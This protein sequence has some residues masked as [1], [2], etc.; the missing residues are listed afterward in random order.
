VGLRQVLIRAYDSA[1]GPE[2]ALN[3]L[4]VLKIGTEMRFGTGPNIAELSI[5]WE[6]KKLGAIFRIKA[7][8]GNLSAKFPPELGMR[9]QAVSKEFHHL[10]L[11]V[12][13]YT[14]ALV[15]RG[16][17]DPMIWIP[18]SGRIVRKEADR[19]LSV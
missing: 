3:S 12:D 7:Q 10:I 16:Q 9:E 15:E 18:Q 11:D 6:D 13:Y 4:Q 1:K 5:R 17:W 19:I 2:D 8:S 14:V